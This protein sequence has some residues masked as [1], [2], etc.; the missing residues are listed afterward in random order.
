MPVGARPW[1]KG[2][3]GNPGGVGGKFREA[4][5]IA[6]DASPEAMRKMVELLDSDDERIVGFAS[7]ELMLHA[8]GAPKTYD[9]SEEMPDN[10]AIDPSQFTPAQRKQLRRMLEM[11]L[12]AMPAEVSEDTSEGKVIDGDVTPES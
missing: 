6:R 3:S 1:V 11:L 12:K 8:W 7:K 2:Q 4:Q 9:P 5:R 10:P